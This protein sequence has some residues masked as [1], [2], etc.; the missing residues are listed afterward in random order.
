MRWWRWPAAVDGAG[1]F[2]RRPGQI[3]GSLLSFDLYNFN[4]SIVLPH[5]GEGRDLQRLSHRLSAAADAAGVS[6][7]MRVTYAEFILPIMLVLGFGTRF[8]AL[9]LL[10]VTAYRSFT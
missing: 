10:L 2:L 1:V 7:L 5:A 8:A 4:F 9:G 3:T 6:P